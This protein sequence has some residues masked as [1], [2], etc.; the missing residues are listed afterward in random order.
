MLVVDASVLV[1]ALADDGP[2]GDRA[3]NRLRGEALAAPELVDLEVVSVL[4]RQ[5]AAG[6]LDARRAQLALADLVDLPLQ[7]ATHLT[8]LPRIWELRNNLSAYDA[9]YVALAERLGATL[10][11]ADV[12]LTRA[13]GPTCSI[14]DF[15]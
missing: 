12:R 2:D 6:S 11:T 8:L 1:V 10:L 9:S 7:R 13:S 14:E 4:R 5:L 3:R 15:T